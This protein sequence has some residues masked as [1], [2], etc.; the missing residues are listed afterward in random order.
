M[1]RKFYKYTNFQGDVVFDFVEAASE[2]EANRIIKNIL[3]L[4]SVT[5]KH[6]TP[7]MYSTSPTTSDI[8]ARINYD[9]KF[10]RDYANAI[11][12]CAND[13][14]IMVQNKPRLYCEHELAHRAFVLSQQLRANPIDIFEDVLRIAAGGSNG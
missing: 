3:A 5:T 8:T 2:I 12:L 11:Q 13:Y 6:T 4:C 14:R 7:R 1:V 10:I 9:D